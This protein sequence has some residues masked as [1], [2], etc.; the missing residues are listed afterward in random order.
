MDYSSDT[1][2]DE[3]VAAAAAQQ[4][5]LS[6]PWYPIVA[7]TLVLETEDGTLMASADASTGA[8]SGVGIDGSGTNTLVSSTGA[9][10]FKLAGTVTSGADVLATYRY[11]NEDV[12]SDG[13]VSAGFTN[14]PEVEMKMNSIPISA[15]ARTL[16][17]F[18]ALTKVA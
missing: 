17:S 6:L 18:W 9:I 14:V 3:I 13:P 2:K 12:R 11:N 10:N 16:R 8:I 7:G 15:Q 5:T 1:V 4:F